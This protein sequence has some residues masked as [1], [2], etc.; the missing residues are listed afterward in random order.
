M[1]RLLVRG[2]RFLVRPVPLSVLSML[3]AC[4]VAI[5]GISAALDF[6]DHAA[7]FLCPGP[8]LRGANIDLALWVALIAGFAGSVVIV[9]V[10]KRRRLL[11]A[12]LLVGATTLG[13][14]VGLV[15]LD[16][17]TYVQQES[18]PGA[19]ATLCA[20]FSGGSGTSTA[21]LGYLYLWGVPLCLLLVQAGRVLR[22]AHRSSPSEPPAWTGWR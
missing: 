1:T 13:V 19:S 21:H 4:A 18:G 22:E 5:Y 17:A 16:S 6:Q 8:L 3:F 10:R 2:V 15:A 14:A 9:V 20:P 7:A 12:V 11:A